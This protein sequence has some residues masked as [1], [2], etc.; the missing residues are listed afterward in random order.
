VNRVDDIWAVVPV[1]EFAE[2]KQRLSDALSAEQRQILAAAMLE[3]VLSVLASVRGLAGIVVVTRDDRARVLAERVGAR[4]IA[5]GA[6]TGQ[7]EAVASVARV[8]AREG[9][10]GML[11]VPADVPLVSTDEVNAILAR[12]GAPPAFTIVPAHDSRGSNAILCSPPDVVPL[13]FGDDSF[14]PHLA[15]ARRMG[16]EPT[17]L[18]LPGIAL[19][20]DQPADL[21]RLVRAGQSRPSQT[22]ALLAKANA[23]SD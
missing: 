18:P 16:I 14:L 9:R 23:T 5:E 4:I 10:G 7:T 12:H 21:E 19:D 1:K 8:L 6:R 22:F 15:A 20:I 17:I 13:R 11:T 3:D 2:A